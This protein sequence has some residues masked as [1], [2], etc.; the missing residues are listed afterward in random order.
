MAP[1][2]KPKKRFW[3]CELDSVKGAKKSI[4]I[5]NYKKIKYSTESVEKV[6]NMFIP[7]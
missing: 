6:V 5:K 2:V 7:S 1:D 3:S 4:D